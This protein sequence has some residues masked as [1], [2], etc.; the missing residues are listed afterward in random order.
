MS[1]TATISSAT[2]RSYAVGQKS[3]PT[4]STR[5]GRPEPPEYTDPSGSAPTTWTFPS[6]ASLRYRPVPEMVPP[7]PTPATKWVIRP[8][9]CSHS[10]GPVE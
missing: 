4:P 2:V 7:V 9:V 5:Y 1:D 10:S 6:L 3:S 8:S